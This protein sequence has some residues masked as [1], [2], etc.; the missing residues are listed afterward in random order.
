MGGEILVGKGVGF[1]SNGGSIVDLG[2][3][4][5][6]SDLFFVEMGNVSED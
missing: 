3:F 1:D 6:L 4:D 2:G 5:E